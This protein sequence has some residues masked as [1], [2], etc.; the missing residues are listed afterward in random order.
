MSTTTEKLQKLD[1]ILEMQQ[2][3]Q[4]DR[5]TEWVEEGL[6]D[7]KN[8]GKVLLVPSDGRPMTISYDGRPFNF[9]ASGRRVPR[10]VAI[11]MLR[12]FGKNG[13]NQGRDVSSG[14]T[15]AEWVRLKPQDREMYSALGI[16]N[17]SFVSQYL[18][19]VPDTERV[20]DNEEE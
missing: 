9:N 15:R 13:I 19:H 4:R 7:E 11:E 3:D 10:R 18:T 5:L 1:D 14:F 6:L 12:C 17:P 2:P 20:E 16:E 8:G